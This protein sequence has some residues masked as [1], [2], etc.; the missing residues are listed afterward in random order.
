[1]ANSIAGMYNVRV[2]NERESEF[3]FV[4]QK[5][6]LITIRVTRSIVNKKRPSATTTNTF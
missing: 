1:M 6:S 4:L 5:L 2:Y 3:L